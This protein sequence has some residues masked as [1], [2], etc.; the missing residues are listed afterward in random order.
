ME[1]KPKFSKQC[2]SCGMPMQDGEV[3][4]TQADGSKSLK[5][6]SLCY[7][8]GRFITPDMTLDEMKKIVDDALKEKGWMWP[9]RWM[10]K[11]Q[12]PSLERWKQ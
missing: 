3:A 10:A 2:Q 6:C 7:E 4:G 5:Y 8:N 11:S 9:L 12:L 1:D